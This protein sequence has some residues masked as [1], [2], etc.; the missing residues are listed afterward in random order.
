[1]KHYSKVKTR[2]GLIGW[3]VG[4]SRSP[5]MHNAAFR[6]LG[7]NWEYM[8][9][10]VHPNHVSEAVR[11]LRGLGFRGANVTVPHKLAVMD[12]LDQIMPEAQVIGAVN[13][14]VNQDNRLI[15]HNTDGIGFL[16][17][18]R[19]GGFEPQGCRALL[20]GA[21]GASRAMLYALL[22]EQVQITIAN[23][24]QSKADA[25]AEEFGAHFNVSINTLAL[26]SS[27][28]LQ[29][30][31]NQADLLVNAT[32]LGMYPHIDTMPLPADTHFHAGLTVY[33]AVYNP[34]E[35][36]LLTQ[37]RAA[38]AKGIDGLGML[39]HQG[40]VAFTLWTGE[41]APVEVMRAAA[42]DV[43]G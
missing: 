18:L 10:P 31:L 33:D 20:I 14:I 12:A 25:L 9:L 16:R 27:D 5:A 8:L 1:M 30:A 11:G 41:D 32:T 26:D 42:M 35:T 28:A 23:R 37:V 43:G 4:H 7:L 6:H 38:G 22:T 39:I 21:G 3:P 24:T 40:A 13:T 36:K 15:G 2:V 19:E 17:A 29:Q 34:L